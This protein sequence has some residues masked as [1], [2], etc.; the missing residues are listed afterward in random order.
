MGMLLLLW[1]ISAFF[2]EIF[3]SEI[4]RCS[5]AVACL[6]P[7]ISLFFLLSIS[8]RSI[9]L[10]GIFWI[11]NANRFLTMP[12]ASALV[13]DNNSIFPVKIVCQFSAYY[14][15]IS[16]NIFS[17]APLILY[18]GFELRIVVNKGIQNQALHL[19]SVIVSKT[20]CALPRKE[21]ARY[22]H[23][24][25]L[26]QPLMSSKWVGNQ[27]KGQFHHMKLNW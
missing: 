9:W 27:A 7:P 8:I 5:Y 18:F 22:K 10:Y 26:F 25:A 15:P 1:L 16:R 21:T 6:G 4:W 11:A 3:I 14:L 23:L 20:S 2:H 13:F 12:S 24:V 19:L 17:A